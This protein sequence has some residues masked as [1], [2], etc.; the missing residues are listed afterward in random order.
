M[1][2]NPERSE[3]LARD[4]HSKLRKKG[5]PTDVDF[6]TLIRS[7]PDVFS[8]SCHEKTS[9]FLEGRACLGEWTV[10]GKAVAFARARTSQIYLVCQDA[11]TPQRMLRDPAARIID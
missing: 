9:P 4:L 11:H 2:H 5:L 1:N 7:L 10:S 6:H 3:S 8:R